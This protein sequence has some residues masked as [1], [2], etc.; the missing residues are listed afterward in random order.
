MYYPGL[1]SLAVATLI[2]A[3]EVPAISRRTKVSCLCEDEAW[4]ITRRWL[5]LF[6]TG[7]LSSKEELATIVSPNIKSY[8]DTFVP[9]VT[10]ID[11][12]WEVITEPGNKTTT[13]ETQTPS[14]LL[15]SCDQI[16][17]NWKYTAVTTGYNSSVPVGTPVYVTGNDILRVDL[18]TGLVSNATSCGNWILLAHQLGGT[19]SI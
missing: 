1:L 9:V 13:N 6:S 18:E 14:F 10:G 12:L 7:G 15:Y 16:A 11:E 3:S 8:D 19:C 2:G 5:G 17:F 4:D